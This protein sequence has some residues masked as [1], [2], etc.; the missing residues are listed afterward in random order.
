MEPQVTDLG[1]QV[2]TLVRDVDGGRGSGRRQSPRE[3]QQQQVDNTASA[4]SVIEG[5]LLTFHNVA[6]LQQKNIELLAVVRELSAGQEAAEASRLEEKTAE[7]RQELDT[8]FWQVEELRTARERQQL[9]V[10][11]IIQQKE[12]YRCQWAGG[13][14]S[15][16]VGGGG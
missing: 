9:M 14:H 7:V 2:T 3:R 12:M 16:E 4:D 1:K 6:E 5:R 10:E 13:C 11:N 15:N 8:A